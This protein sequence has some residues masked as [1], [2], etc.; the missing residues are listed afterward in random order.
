MKIQ[1][2][3]IIIVG[4]YS[5]GQYLAPNFIAR[6]YPCVHIQ[7]GK[8]INPYFYSSYKPDNFIKNIV[9]DE[10]DNEVLK[11]L[12][13][14]QVNIII[15]GSEMAVLLAD[16]LSE[17]L[18][19][20][21]TNEP[22][23]SE[24]RRNKFLMQ[25]ALKSAGLSHIKHF[26]ASNVKNIQA[27]I[28]QEDIGYPVV[29]KPLASCG[30]DGVAICH[31]DL[32]IESAFAVVHNGVNAFGNLNVEVLA[33]QFLKGEEYVV[34][35][36]SYDGNHFVTDIIKVN[37]TLI[38]NSP[39]YDYAELLSP[40]ENLEI[41]INLSTYIKLVLDAL[42]IKFGPGHSEIMLINDKTPVLIETAARPIGGIDPSAY[43][44][45]LGYN[46]MSVTVDAYLN[47]KSFHKILITEEMTL[48]NYLI[49]VFCISPFCGLIKNTPVIDK[50]L[51]LK[52]FHSLTLQDSGELKK[53][54]TLL[55]CPGYINLISENKAELFDDY[56]KIRVS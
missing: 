17:K 7:P 49:C 32:E 9:W 20:Y 42:G 45:A 46:Q 22:N 1:K 10:N 55:D 6:G 5:T 43:V 37:K 39:V 54:H 26:K 16:R 56:K 35:T 29:I 30:T 34:N 36:V 15:P 27:W 12:S 3:V 4:A 47:P 48:R 31:N 53:T 41:Y 50:I 2:K 18:G 11:Q 8:V 24:A 52:A 33:Q 23:L 14:F 21:T 19:L 28:K 38:D 13:E 40:K 44:E 51:K 25:E